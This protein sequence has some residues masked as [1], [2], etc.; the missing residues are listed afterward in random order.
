MTTIMICD[1]N[2][3]Q[4]E[5]TCQFVRAYC[6]SA[7]NI[8]IKPIR[9]KQLSELLTAR[10]FSASILITE[11]ALNGCSG[12]TIA[13]TVN[14]MVPSCKI[15]YL[16]ESL[17]NALDVYETRHL[18][19]VL[20]KQMEEILPKALDKAFLEEKLTAADYFCFKSQ[21]RYVSLLQ[22]EILYIDKDG[23]YSYVHTA[24]AVYQCT[25]PISK[26]AESLNP[27]WFIRCHYGYIVNLSCISAF[28]KIQLTLD[29]QKVIPVGRTFYKQTKEAYLGQIN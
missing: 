19:F 25:L 21:S 2:T 8:T 18:Y 4:L 15:I 7:D 29:E 16:C 3:E 23:R 5:R 27:N 9:P 12:L 1:S 22:K 14:T 20:K 6:H 10:K 24:T 28:S 26:L 13:R 17:E 11:I